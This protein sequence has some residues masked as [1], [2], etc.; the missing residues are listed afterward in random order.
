M[1][2]PVCI[3][4]CLV[5]GLFQADYRQLSGGEHS[6]HQQHNNEQSKYTNPSATVA[7]MGKTNQSLNISK[8]T[9]VAKYEYENHFC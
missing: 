3:A 1:H 7:A 6:P 4:K 8:G 5:S 9:S 2:M